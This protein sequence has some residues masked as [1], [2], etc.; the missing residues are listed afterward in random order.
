MIPRRD[1]QLPAD[2]PQVWRQLC[3]G[4]RH[5]M[6]ARQAAGGGRGAAWHGGCFP[7]P[8]ASFVDDWPTDGADEHSRVPA[9]PAAAPLC[10]AP[11]LASNTY[12]SYGCEAGL[13][14]PVLCVGAGEACVDTYQARWRAAAVAAAATGMGCRSAPAGG[15][16]GAHVQRP[17][18][19]LADPDPNRPAPAPSALRL[20][21][22]CRR[23][24][25]LPS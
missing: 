1:Q 14:K 25:P 18:M 23:A 16:H 20:L 7:L 10:S 6:P 9:P 17:C 2:G 24:C 5:H 3:P 12:C 21:R 19:R 22:C 4:V 15:L 8:R 11:A 13:R